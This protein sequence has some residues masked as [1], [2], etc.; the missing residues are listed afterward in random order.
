MVVVVAVDNVV[1]VKKE[2][3]SVISTFTVRI[4]KYEA[5]GKTG[6]Q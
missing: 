3:G 5:I 2:K 4:K 6:K 1:S